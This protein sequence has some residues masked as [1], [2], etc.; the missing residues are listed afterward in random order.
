MQ[1]IKDKLTRIMQRY[2]PMDNDQCAAEVLEAAEHC[3]TVEMSDELKAQLDAFAEA[4][5]VP[6]NE[7]IRLAI[8]AFVSVGD[9]DKR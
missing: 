3:I 4:V 7:V 9:V 8:K 1:T 5:G 2:H 6:R